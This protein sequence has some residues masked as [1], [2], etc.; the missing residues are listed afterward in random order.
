MSAAS[1]SQ[2]DRPLDE[3]IWNLRKRDLSA[4]VRQIVEEAA[5]LLGDGRVVEASALIDQA[6]ATS[7]LASTSEA[8]Y[9]ETLANCDEAAGSDVEQALAARLVTDIANGL[10]K[11][12]VE[13]IQGLE[14]HFTGETRRLTSALSCRLDRI[15]AN[16]E[17]LQPLTERLESL[18]QSGA[19][20]EARYEQLAATTACLQEADSRHDAEIHTLQLQ[21]QELSVSS[22]DRMNEICHRIEEQER[23]ISSANSTT[24]DLTARI[25]AVAERL[26]RHADAIRSLHQEHQQGAAALNQ[27]A[28]VLG[29]MRT[30]AEALQT[31]AAL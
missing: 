12:L 7:S 13:A 16:I 30:A 15:Q 18:V 26:E 29:R 19:A 10:A 31:V 14:R 11:V 22:R 3:R 6:E 25:E 1:I 24:S 27:V 23:L 8:G 9:A 21:L 17:C 20:V 4:A 2:P 28:E 5:Q